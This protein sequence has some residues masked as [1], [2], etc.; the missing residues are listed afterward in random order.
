MISIQEIR[1]KQNKII[2]L[3]NHGPIIQSI[4]DFDYLSGKKEGSVINIVTGH[5]GYAK[6][7]FGRQEILIPTLISI[8]DFGVR[9]SDLNY[10]F[11]NLLSGRRALSSTLEALQLRGDSSTGDMTNGQVGT[12]KVGG[13]SSLEFCGGVIFAEGVPEL[14]ALNIIEQN[15]KLII[16]PASVGLLVPGCL[17][18]GP[19]GGITPTQIIEGK[20]VHPGSV[21]ILSA[22]GG[23]TNELIN[24]ATQAGHRLSFALSFGGDRFPVLSP[25]DAFL[26]AESD[27]ETK[28]ILYYGELGG[29]DE[30]ELVKLKQEGKFTKNVIAHIAGTVASLF[31]ESPQFGHAKA[32]ADKARTTALAKHIVLKSAGFQVGNSFT[33]FIRLINKL[34]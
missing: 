29:E 1:D 18:L 13:V 22:S 16:G 25:R 27:V 12:P 33:E 14:H 11:L 24:I 6:Y 7:F 19:I 5:R 28:T 34:K 20:F 23:M 2:V 31:P 10:W 17:K 3:G 15:S 21:A 4:L 26:L 8:S 9:S 32:K 30:Y